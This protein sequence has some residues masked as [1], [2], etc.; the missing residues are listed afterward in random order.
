MNV[1]NSAIINLKVVRYGLSIRLV[2]VLII[3]F[4]QMNFPIS[5]LVTFMVCRHIKFFMSSYIDPPVHMITQKVH[6][7]RD[8]QCFI[9]VI[10]DLTEGGGVFKILKFWTRMQQN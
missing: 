10:L 7:S 4:I 5:V 2:I 3:A 8:H 9:D 1:H 6:I